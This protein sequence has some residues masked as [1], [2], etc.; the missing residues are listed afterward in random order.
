[1]IGRQ[2]SARENAVGQEYQQHRDNAEIDV[3]VSVIKGMV[4][5]VADTGLGPFLRIVGIVQQHQLRFV[6]IFYI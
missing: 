6:T 1:M 2:G 5:M 3:V 4:P